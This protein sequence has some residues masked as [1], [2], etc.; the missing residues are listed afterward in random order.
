MSDLIFDNTTYVRVLTD[1]PEWLVVLAGQTFST[2][3]D[4]ET[5]GTHAE[6]VAAGYEGEEAPDAGDA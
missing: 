3:Q 2:M 1:P 5:H 6:A 4:Y